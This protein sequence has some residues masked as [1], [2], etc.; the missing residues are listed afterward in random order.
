MD[1]PAVSTPYAADKLITQ[2]RA[3]AAEYRRAMGKPLPG[4]SAEIAMHDAM[5]LLQLQPKTDEQGG[6]DALDP[7]T[8]ERVQIK[9]R[10]IFE[11]SRGGER[12][13][14]L[15]LNQP[16]DAV[17]LVLMDD[18]YEPTEIYRASRE[19][20]SEYLEQASAS[21]ARRGAMSVARFK[22]LGELVWDVVNGRQDGTWENRPD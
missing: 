12:I 9:S 20:L 15:R 16:W 8:G 17:V 5:R 10:A 2:A 21:R 18:N 14:Q 19:D 22:I 7:A 3:L 13:G 4:V 6:W 11:D 1:I